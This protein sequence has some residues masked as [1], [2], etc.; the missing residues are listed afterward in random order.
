MR[1]ETQQPDVCVYC[2]QP[3]L[4][5]QLPCKVLSSGE[6]AHLDCYVDN[7]HKEEKKPKG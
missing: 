7:M 6:K 5:Q 2:K 4:P 3:I 1:E